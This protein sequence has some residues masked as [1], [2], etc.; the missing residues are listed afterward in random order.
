[1]RFGKASGI[2][3]SEVNFF[4]KTNV[5]SPRRQLFSLTWPI[6]LEAVLFSVIGSV[7]TLM[8]SG[9]ADNAVGAVG[10]ANQIMSL[11]QVISNIITAGTGILC[12]QYIGAGRT[13]EEKQPLILG[14]LMVNGVLGVGFSLAAGVGAGGLLDLMGV[15]PEQRGYA[16]EYMQIVGSFLFVQMIAVT[17]TSLIRA[18]GKT[19]ATMGFSLL[20]NVVNMGLNYVLIYG[21]LGIEPMGAAGAAV[22][23]VISKCLACVLAGGYLIKVVLPDLSFRPNW[24]A[25]GQA[26]KQILAFGSPAAGEQISYTLSKLV[27]MAMVT[28]LGPVAVNTY[29]Y[30]NMVVGYVYLFS[31]AIGQGTSIMVGWEAGRRQTENAKS[32]CRFSVNVSTLCALGALGVLCLLRRQVMDLFTNDDAIITMGAAVIVSDLVLEIGRSRNLVLVNSL[33]AAGDVRYPLYIGLFSMWFFS[34]GISWVLGIGLGWGLVG[35]WIGLGLDECFRAAL[36][37]I[38]WEKGTWIRFV[39]A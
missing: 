15:S 34:V 21:K 13:T 30:V 11:F 14:A 36:L 38:R 27:V 3:G 39:K 20:M 26:V 19:K 24:K 31:M 8:L 32:I 16:V 33:R 37:Q 5:L 28:H 25:M 4:V 12:A 2:L 6:F 17:F 18:H 10:L 7:D 29:S 23:T 1:M 9:Y 22:A 35:I